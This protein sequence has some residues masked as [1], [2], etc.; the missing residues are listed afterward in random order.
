MIAED[1]ETGKVLHQE[2][3]EY[4]EIGLDIEGRMRYGA[5]QIKE[6]AD[7]TLPPLQK[8]DER[9]LFTLPKE[10]EEALVDVKVYYCINGSKCDVVRSISKKVSYGE[11]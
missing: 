8:R 9:F 11:D 10:T 5:W 4:F 7:L 3:K 1:P 2:K 6:L